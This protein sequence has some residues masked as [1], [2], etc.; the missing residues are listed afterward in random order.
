[1]TNLD[2]DMRYLQVKE[3]TFENLVGNCGGYI[4][5]FVGYSIFQ[6]PDLLLSFGAWVHQLKK[7][8]SSTKNGDENSKTLAW[9][10]EE[11]KNRIIFH[12]IKTTTAK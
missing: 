2:T 10:L 11:S 1:M 7:K 5:L 12:N 3:I 4:G 8:W 6:L 9:D